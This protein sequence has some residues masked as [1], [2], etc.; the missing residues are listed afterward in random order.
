MRAMHEICWPALLSFLIASCARTQQGAVPVTRIDLP[1]LDKFFSLNGFDG[2]VRT[3]IRS[4]AEWERFWL[5]QSLPTHAKAPLELDFSRYMVLIAGADVA[6]WNV[7]GTSIDS[8]SRQRDTIL[9]YITLYTGRPDSGFANIMPCA[10]SPVSDF[11]IQRTGLPVQF[12]EPDEVV[13]RC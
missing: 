2:S 7:I 10:I 6:P 12:V 4:A 11:V 13:G 8:V 1:A 9:A 5:S 3:V